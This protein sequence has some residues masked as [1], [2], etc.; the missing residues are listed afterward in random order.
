M[1]QKARRIFI[2]AALGTMAGLYASISFL[3]NIVWWLGALI[4]GIIAGFIY[5]LPDIVRYSPNAFRIAKK[6][7]KITGEGFFILGMLFLTAPIDI[8]QSIRGMSVVKKLSALLYTIGFAMVFSWLVLVVF[9]PSNIKLLVFV[10]GT[11]YWFYCCVIL[12]CLV[13]SVCKNDTE[14]KQIKRLKKAIFLVTPPGFLFSLFWLTKRFGPLAASL[15]FMVLAEFG[16][17]L[18]TFVKTLFFFIHSRELVLCAIDAG[19]AVLISYPLLI[20]AGNLQT[21]P[22]IIF[23]GLL[24]GLFG[25]LHFEI[26]SVRLMH[27][28]R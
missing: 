6:D 5:G 7:L 12:I 17:F 24:G 9:L 13:A 19:F 10:L 4:G 1:D 20:T 23:G 15:V 25:V 8:Y 21:G 14:E 3:P 2:A 26:V 27:L 18:I 16:R 11:I 28:V 22:A